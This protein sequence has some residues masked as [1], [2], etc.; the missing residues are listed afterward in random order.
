MAKINVLSPYFVTESQTNL[1]SA[2]IDIWIYTGTAATLPNSADP[3]YTLSSTAVNESVTFE[4]GELIKDYIDI[5]YTGTPSANGHTVYVDYVVTPFINNAPASVNVS[6]LDPTGDVIRNF[7]FY[8]YGYHEL[9]ENPQLD[10]V[11]LMDATE[12]VVPDGETFYIPATNTAAITWTLKDPSGTTVDSG[13]S[14]AQTNTANIIHYVSPTIPALGDPELYANPLTDTW[15]DSQYESQLAGKYYP[16]Y[17]T[18]NVDDGTTNEDLVIKVVCE[19]KFTPIKCTFVNRYGAF[20]EFWFDKRH[21]VMSKVEKPK[22]F[23]RNIVSSGAYNKYDRVYKRLLVNGKRS[24]TLNTG[25]MKEESNDTV[26]QLLYSEEVW[27][28]YGGHTLPVTPKTDDIKYLQSVNGEFASH[29]IEFEFAFD[30]IN[31][32]K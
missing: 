29:K 20:E 12:F 8:G 1:T 3:T 17:F 24:L 16:R 13:S 9:E 32:I 6:A 5:I 26:E 19:P 11:I 18:L 28:K 22:E 30:R 23:K 7:A 10:K 2:Q 25:F 27:V 14:S 4:I 21:D 31:N 15:G